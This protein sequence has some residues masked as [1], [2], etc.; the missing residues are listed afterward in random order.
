MCEWVER[1]RANLEKGTLELVQFF[2]RCSGC[3][4]GITLDDYRNKKAVDIIQEITK[5][6]DEVSCAKIIIFMMKIYFIHTINEV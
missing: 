1:Y 4:A 2:V 3:L 5:N 6:F